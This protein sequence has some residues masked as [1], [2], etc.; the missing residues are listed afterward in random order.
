M[1]MTDKPR[2]RTATGPAVIKLFESENELKCKN[3]LRDFIE[4]LCLFL[5]ICENS[6]RLVIISE[7][8]YNYLAKFISFPRKLNDKILENIIKFYDGGPWS[9]CEL[10]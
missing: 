2:E 8:R 1:I 5:N 9:W 4:T 6:L 7:Y 10:A 3:R